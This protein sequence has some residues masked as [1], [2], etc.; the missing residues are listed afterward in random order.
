MKQSGT[1]GDEWRSHKLNGLFAKRRFTIQWDNMLTDIVM[2]NVVE[3]PVMD[4]VEFHSEL[5]ALTNSSDLTQIL[6]VMFILI[7]ILILVSREF[8][9]RRCMNAFCLRLS[10]QYSIG[11]SFL[12]SPLPANANEMLKYASNILNFIYI[13][14][15]RAFSKFK[16]IDTR[17]HML[18]IR[19]Q[20]IRIHSIKWKSHKKQFLTCPEMILV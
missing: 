12:I 13:N 15:P 16:H 1:E 20:H 19:N 18:L 14:T 3:R 5:Q 6:C 8:E 4:L 7:L 17:A 2:P 9:L 11:V 10:I